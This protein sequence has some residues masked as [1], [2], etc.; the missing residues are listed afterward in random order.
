VKALWVLLR[1]RVL[2]VTRSVSA[3]VAFFGLP[4]LILLLLALVF[5]HGH[6]FE[7][8]SVAV[9]AQTSELAAVRAALGGRAELRLEAEPSEQVARRKLEVRA[10]EA[11][12]L[13][14]EAKPPL[15]LVG[16]RA[17]IW[18]RGLAALLPNSAS[19]REV[20]ISDFGYLHY[21]FPG[22]LCTSVMFAGL[23]GMGYAMARYRQNSFL[24][25]LSTTPLA[26]STFVVAQVLGRG[27][28]VVV[29][30]AL[31][32]AVGLFA[33]SLPAPLSGMLSAGVV[34]LLGL[35]VF[36]GIGFALACVIRTEAVLNDVISALTLPI[37]L[38]SGMFFPIDVLPRP[39]FEL[40]RRLP[41]TL[42]V[43]AARATLLY[44]ANLASVA[45][46]LLGLVLWGIA[47][48]SLSIRVFRWHD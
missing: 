40:S 48:F 14:A 46:A 38:F 31:L 12:I 25:K 21:L 37:S 1:M 8:K 47:A 16:V 28:L 17:G 29:Q 5:A 26:R 20:S 19:V 4:V 13:A 18:G 2:D 7:S 27:S 44:G 15:V 34:T 36:S 11:V 10:V 39:L 23:Y 30:V 22:L 24:K 3:S 43:D 9:V 42:M 6:P 35:L 33:F 32:L 41:S 45:P